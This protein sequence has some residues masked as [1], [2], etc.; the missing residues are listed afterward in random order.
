MEFL[1][2]E[3][4]HKRLFAVSFFSQKYNKN[5]LEDLIKVCH[6]NRNGYYFDVICWLDRL[7][8]SPEPINSYYKSELIDKIKKI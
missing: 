3:K 2:D 7:I 1:N 4:D 5:K 8:Y 6:S